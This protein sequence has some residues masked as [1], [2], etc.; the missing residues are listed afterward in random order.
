M[1]IAGYEYRVDGGEPVDVGDVLTTIVAG[2]Q[3]G[4]E[5]DFEVRS[6]NDVGLRSP[7]SSVV[8]AA[9]LSLF[10]MITAV[11]L[12]AY[13]FRRLGDYTGP[14]MRV[15]RPS[16]DAETNLSL[17]FTKADADAF[18]ADLEVVKLFDQMGAHDINFSPRPLLGFLNAPM[19]DWGAYGETAASGI[20]E[21]TF[22]LAHPKFFVVSDVRVTSTYFLHFGSQTFETSLRG[23]AGAIILDNGAPVV[24]DSMAFRGTR[25]D[26]IY[27][28]SGNDAVREQGA[29]LGVLSGTNAGDTART[30]KTLTIGPGFGS[31]SN[32]YA[33]LWGELLIFDGT[34]SSGDRDIIEASQMAA[35]ENG[36]R[37][38]F[39]GDS[40]MY[41]ANLDL[42][43]REQTNAPGETLALLGGGW[44]GYNR[45]TAGDRY[46]HLIADAPTQ[47]DPL[48]RAGAAKNIVVVWAGFNDFNT[49]ATVADVQDRIETYC[50][51]RQAVGW[52]VVVVSLPISTNAV[53][54]GYEANRI[55]VN[56]WI[57][58]NWFSFANGYADLSD[59]PIIGDDADPTDTDY[60][61]DSIHMTAEGYALVAPYIANAITAMGTDIVGPSVPASL[62]AGTPDIT[63]IPFTWAVST[64]EPVAYQIRRATDSGFTT[65]VVDTN[66]SGGATTSGSVTGLT[67][68]TLYYFKIRARDASGN[69]SGYSTAISETTD[70][71]APIAPGDFGADLHTYL[72]AED[73]ALAD[74]AGITAWVNNGYGQDWNTGGSV[75]KQTV[76]GQKVARHS[77]GGNLFQ[78]LAS[79][80]APGTPYT[81]Y[82]IAKAA[83]TTTQG[84]LIGYSGDTCSIFANLSATPGT[85]RAF[86]TGETLATVD[87]A[88]FQMIKNTYGTPING[89]W[90]IGENYVGDWAVVV[91]ID[92]ALTAPETA[93]LE[94]WLQARVTA[95]NT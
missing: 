3:S 85:W 26:S 49:G 44:D 46:T 80:T 32:Q 15:L 43:E 18:G 65:G 37:I 62:T 5:Y 21:G 34:V 54:A 94:A 48:F 51:A 79:E 52:Q 89:Y 59:D 31:G 11:P 91:M 13:S 24:F 77:G 29:A 83:D 75:T 17:G 23:D 78:T 90:R 14:A 7:W 58:D 92:R 72:D 19:L 55:A 35:F 27:Y 2:L 8:S 38:A 68:G 28:Q 73:Q 95:L 60:W 9:T 30:G 70:A 53:L 81:L 66:F 25:Q 64:G 22:D 40:L 42:Y 6:Y 50:L 69:W 41:G 67:G 82:A 84:R 39:D 47:I 4:T 63:E 20:A 61:Q 86:V 56:D 87:T 16:D 71:I 93:G 57:A 45:G 88:N 74:G 33:G 12:A 76:S 1:A 10:D 36:Y